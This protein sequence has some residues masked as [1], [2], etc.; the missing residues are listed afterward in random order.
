MESLG[1]IETHCCHLPW[2]NKELSRMI[3]HVITPSPPPPS[4]SSPMYPWVTSITADHRWAVIWL[5]A[6]RTEIEVNSSLWREGRWFLLSN[7]ENPIIQQTLL[8]GRLTV[9][10]HCAKAFLLKACSVVMWYEGMQC[11]HVICSLVMWS[12]ACSV[13]M[14]SAV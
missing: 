9:N 13:V 6:K 7:A 4:W 14:W 5:Q 1:C 2:G 10:N 12:E 11:N 8:L 3:I